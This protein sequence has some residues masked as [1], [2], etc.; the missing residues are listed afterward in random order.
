MG[1]DV[2]NT[3]SGVINAGGYGFNIANWEKEV[4]RFEKG[5]EEVRA[6][7]TSGGPGLR[8]TK[9]DI[10]GYLKNHE[11]L[12]ALFV[13]PGMGPPRVP[14]F[15][16]GM[17]V[18]IGFLSGLWLARLRAKRMGLDPEILTDMSFWLLVTGVAGG[19][20]EDCLRALAQG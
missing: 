5:S 20:L 6:V 4:A 8:T 10:P 7:K 11:L 15:G 19:R 3:S 16:Y 12:A 13:L 9:K 18:L 17:M 1:G 2:S 14:I